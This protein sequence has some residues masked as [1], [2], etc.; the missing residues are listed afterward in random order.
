M[1]VFVWSKLR[2]PNRVS[3]SKIKDKLKNLLHLCKI[4]LRFLIVP[5]S[6]GNLSFMIWP[7]LMVPLMSIREFMLMSLISIC[8]SLMLKIK[9]NK[10]KHSLSGRHLCS[11]LMVVWCLEAISRARRTAKPRTSSQTPLKHKS[12]ISLNACL[13]NRS[14]S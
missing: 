11:T 14:T 13:V 10:K 12:E 4:E 9:R 8:L 6:M 1:D 2:L 3:E 5:L 7:K